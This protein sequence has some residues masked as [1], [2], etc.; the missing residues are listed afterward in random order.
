MVDASA[1]LSGSG[2]QQV[3]V[4]HRRVGQNQAGNY[5]QFYVE[6]RYYG[7]G[8]GSWT[9]GTLYWS[10]DVSGWH[11]EGSFTIPYANRFDTYTVLYSGYY[12]R[13]HDSAGNL[14][15]FNGQASIN[16]NVHSSIGSGTAYFTEPASPRIPKRPSAPPFTI[17]N[18]ESDSFKVNVSA[19]SNDG[20]SSISSYLIR[21]STNPQADTPG[22]YTDYPGSGTQTIRGQTPGTTRYVTVYAKNGSADNN[23]YSTYQASKRVDLPAGVYVSD[24]SAWR[25][26]GLNSSNGSA[27]SSLVPQYSDGDSWEDP[28]DV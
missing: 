21:V 13:A 3:W 22:S 24:G 5:S 12:N 4:Q 23:G 28:I 15:A 1:P 11:V 17:S 9:N 25:A 7:N 27:W 14:G 8:N 10:A 26:Q 20:G 18:V 16:G 6:V 19:P 2:P